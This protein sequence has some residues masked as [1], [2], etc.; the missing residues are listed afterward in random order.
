[1]TISYPLDFTSLLMPARIRWIADEVVGESVSPF[2]LNEQLYDWNAA[3]LGFHA[4]FPPCVRADAEELVAHLLALAGR[5][6]TFLYW[7]PANRSPRGSGASDSPVVMGSGTARART[8]ATDGWT[9]GASGLLLRGDWFQVGSGT[10]S[11]L[12]K[13]LSP[14]N[15]DAYGAATL[16]IW[17]PLREDLADGDPLVL[18]DPKGTFRLAENVR[19]WD[20]DL[21]TI[22][23]V[24]LDAVEAI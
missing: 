22:Y 19:A 14:V 13:V 12:H 11:R 6:G 8:L 5:A 21:A 7:P 4:S 1:M 3:R 20:I 17:P 10:S 15:A 18:V 2:T 24:E 16:D 23:G 9:A